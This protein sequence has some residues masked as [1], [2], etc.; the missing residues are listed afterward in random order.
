MMIW[1]VYYCNCEHL[2][3]AVHSIADVALPVPVKS[4]WIILMRSKVSARHC[5]LLVVNEK[6]ITLDLLKSCSSSM[7]NDISLYTQL[8]RHKIALLCICIFADESSSE[9]SLLSAGCAWVS[10][11]SPHQQHNSLLLCATWLGL[12]T[13]ALTPATPSLSMLDF[14]HSHSSATPHLVLMWSW[15]FYLV[16]ML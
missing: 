2:L 15:Y 4:N 7:T 6:L 16:S 9:C 8:Y 3:T 14:L 13:P 10:V 1:C 5:L 12:W 11:L